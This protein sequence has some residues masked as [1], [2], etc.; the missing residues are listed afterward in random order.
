[1]IS[2]HVQPGATEYTSG[3]C[4][5]QHNTAFLDAAI[6]PGWQLPDLL[7]EEEPFPALPLCKSQIVYTDFLSIS[8]NLTVLILS[9][10]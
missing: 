3:A 4:F 2:Y 10:F 8:D 5:L 9:R 7:R 1:M 6:A